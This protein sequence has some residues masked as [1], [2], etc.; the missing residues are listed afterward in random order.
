M[1]D[2][3]DPAVEGQDP[4]L[5]SPEPNARRRP[6]SDALK[7]S[8]EESHHLRIAV[9]RMA[10]VVGSFPC[11]AIKLGVSTNTLYHA[12]RPGSRPVGTLAIRL[13]ALARVPVEVLLGGKM[14]VA[15]IVVGVAA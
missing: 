11:L 13:A 10:K 6:K 3:L 1:T 7:L 15:P 8:P 12:A 4:P 2:L 5:S 9:R 14:V